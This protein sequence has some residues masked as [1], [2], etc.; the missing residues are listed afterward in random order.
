MIRT[1]GSLLHPA[2]KEHVLNAF[3]YRMT[4]ESVARFPSATIKDYR[5]TLISDAEWLSSTTFRVR[6]SDR[7]LHLGLKYCYHDPDKFR[8]RKEN[9]NG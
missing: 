8:T 7:R 6:K 5:L 3:H 2:D 4:Y 9:V 1:L